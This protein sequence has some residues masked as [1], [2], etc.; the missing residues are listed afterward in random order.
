[1]K[2]FDDPRVTYED[3][4]TDDD[5]DLLEDCHQD[6]YE[7]IAGNAVELM[8]E[9]GT[10]TTLMK[11]ILLEYYEESEEDMI[12]SI[13]KLRES[14]WNNNYVQQQL[15]KKRDELYDQRIGD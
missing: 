1:M 9:E 8:H 7:E 4:Y 14:F 10:F 6:A 5:E 15:I 13:S 11:R 12:E 2:E 3:S